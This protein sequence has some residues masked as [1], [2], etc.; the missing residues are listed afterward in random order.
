[1][2]Y[3]TSNKNLILIWIWLDTKYMF[4]IS[5]YFIMYCTQFFFIFWTFCLH[6]LWL[7]PQRIFEWI[8]QMIRV[9]ILYI[10][11]IINYESCERETQCITNHESWERSNS[12]TI[13]ESSEQSFLLPPKFLFLSR[14]CTMSILKF[15]VRLDQGYIVMQLFAYIWCNPLTCMSW[16]FAIH[17]SFSFWWYYWTV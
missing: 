1:M 2:C 17:N 3:F 13:L 15:S 12:K 11:Y 14:K 6:I 16:S 7:N 9:C 5:I 10:L 4:P 8:Y